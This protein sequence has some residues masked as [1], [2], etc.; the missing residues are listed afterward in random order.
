M[1]INSIP[2][3]EYDKRLTTIETERSPCMLRHAGSRKKGRIC[4]V[5]IRL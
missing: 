2:D 1:N 5:E 3:S 4:Y